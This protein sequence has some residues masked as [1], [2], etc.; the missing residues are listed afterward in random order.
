MTADQA[1]ELLLS[2]SK[3]PQL[4]EEFMRNPPDVLRARTLTLSEEEIVKAREILTIFPSRRLETLSESLQIDFGK[5]AL[6]VWSSVLRVVK[7][8]E[9]GF[10]SVMKTYEVAFYAGIILIALS[11][12][13]SL[14]V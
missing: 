2:L 14:T 4:R 8:I 3:D 11:V 12:L 1:L 7:Q 13:L 5:M 6:E 9:D 10:T